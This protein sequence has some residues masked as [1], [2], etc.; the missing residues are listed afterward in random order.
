MHSRREPTRRGFCELAGLGVAAHVVGC[1]GDDSSATSDGTGSGSG[2]DGDDDDDVSTDAGLDSSD[3]EAGS[4]NAGSDEASDDSD[5]SSTDDATTTDTGD[6]GGS[7]ETGEVACEPSPPSIEGPFY[8]PGIPVRSD[9]DI[10]GDEGLP[11][12]MSG[13]VLDSS[14]QPVANAVV[15]IW[16]AAPIPPGTE[17]E[18]FDAT[19]DDTREFRYYG[20][21]ATDANGRYE[22]VTLRPGWYLNGAQYRPAHIHVKIWTGEDERLT[23]QLYF[24]DDPFA[25][26][27]PWFDPTMVLDLDENGVVEFDF[28]I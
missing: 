20:Q 25:D 14:C 13:R 16:H 19:Y 7:S 4:S 5:G 24:V 9:L 1:A 26:I 27:D 2:S 10:Y 12:H 21:V 15:E 8:R 11:V 18:A 6:T 28:A 17:P 22:F 23:S 3:G